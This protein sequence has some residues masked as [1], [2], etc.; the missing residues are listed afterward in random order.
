M[1]ESYTPHVFGWEHLIYLFLFFAVSGG[2]LTA[3]KLKVK[4]EKTLDII[5]KCLGGFLLA[6]IIWNRISI[7]IHKNSAWFLIPDS[8]CGLSS[9][10]L[11]VCALACKRDALPFHCLCYISFWGGAIVTFYPDFLG[12][13]SSFMYHATI[14]GMLHHGIA[15]YISVLM[16]ITGYVKP[17]LKKF[18]AFPVGLCFFMCFG[19]FL[20]DALGFETAMFIGKPLI[21]NTYLTW[22]V[23]S[24]L[25]IGGTLAGV[26]IYEYV[27]K[28]KSEKK[29]P[30]TENAEKINNFE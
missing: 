14:S 7:A 24:V 8:F 26:C 27:L 22:Y 20:I 28:K 1:P 17:S 19:I 15:L 5:I 11:A 12:Q 2:T 10:C 13:A 21:P 23:M 16:G 18:Y 9:L 30:D 6:L 29:I 4:K 3:V 25:L